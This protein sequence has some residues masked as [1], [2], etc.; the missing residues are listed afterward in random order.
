MKNFL[1]FFEENTFSSAKA[2]ITIQEG[3]KL[4][5]GAF[6]SVGRAFAFIKIF[7]FRVVWKISHKFD[8]YIFEIG[9]LAAKLCAFEM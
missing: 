6:S 4:S 8:I 7:F 1:I 3:I 2:R 5:F 9:S